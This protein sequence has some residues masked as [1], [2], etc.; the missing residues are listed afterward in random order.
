MLGDVECVD[1]VELTPKNQKSY[2]DESNRIESDGCV[3]Y[4]TIRKINAPKHTA[5]SLRSHLFSHTNWILEHLPTATAHHFIGVSMRDIHSPEITWK[6]WN[7]THTHTHTD[8]LCEWAH[9]RALRSFTVWQ[10]A[11]HFFCS[12]YKIVLYLVVLVRFVSFAFFSMCTIFQCSSSITFAQ[13]LTSI[14]HLT[15]T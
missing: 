11:P 14:R 13:R 10:C 1:S 8:V 2:E 12:S 9:L 3:C 7:H 6:L 4:F 15:D 5:H